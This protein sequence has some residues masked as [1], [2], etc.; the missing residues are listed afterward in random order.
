MNVEEEIVKSPILAMKFGGTSVGSV[1]AI[2]QSCEIV[3]STLKDWPRTVVVLSALSGVTNQLLEGAARATEGDV[4]AAMAVS[5]QL[6]SR[7]HAT[8]D[9][10]LEDLSDLAE[11][12]QHCDMLIDEFSNLCGAIS[13]LGE[14][15]PRALDAV[16]SLGERLS[17]RLFRLVLKERGVSAQDIESTRL[18]LTDSNFQS[19]HPDWDATRRQSQQV[20][21]PLLNQG[22]VPVVTGFLGA[23][24]DG[25]TTTLGRGGSDYSAAIL[26]AAIRAA[27][28]WI[29][30]DVDGVMTADPRIVQ[31][32]MTIPRISYLEL[33]ELAYFGAKVLHP[34]T[35][36]PV[37][38]AGI[39]LSIR[40]TF[41]PD[42][43]G[44]RL[45]PRLE[46]KDE[47]GIKAVTAVRG[48]SLIT[49]EGSG[50]L[51]VP[52]VAA[53][54]FGAVAG[55][56]TNVILISQASSEQ[57]ISFAV[58]LASADQVVTALEGAFESE[59]SN[60]E[61]DRIWATGDAVIVTVVGSGMRHTPGVAGK[62]FS[63]LGEENVNVIAIAQGSSEV[64]ISLV[65]DSPDMELAVRTLH[66][67]VK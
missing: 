42:H 20:L 37:L 46:K 44:T 66:N 7:H 43:S 61:I 1:D 15:T 54:A 6:R 67:L 25:V 27:E 47:G 50:M 48:Q 35:V 41:N 55:T 8:A 52:G 34:K 53:R 33:A 60:R 13:V 45:V 29:W 38:D 23:N 21:I 24:S 17:I 10:L 3:S 32:A 58:P 19:A 11:F 4:T 64:A 59:L 62:V 31:G 26:A 2:Q 56:G 51:G 40:N 18:I 30:T 22:V 39:Q 16:A 14:A 65:V 12:K 9:G 5:E 63:G 36:R 28:V 57:S 49:I